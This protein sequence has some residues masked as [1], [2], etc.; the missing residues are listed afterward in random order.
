MLRG[1][2]SVAATAVLLWPALS[3]GQSSPPAPTI[4]VF[5]SYSINA[6]YIAQPFLIVVDQPVSPFLSTGG[7]PYGFEVSVERGFRRHLGLKASVSRYVDP[8]FGSAAYCQPP[9]LSL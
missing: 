8:F 7:G 9:L 6:D 2:R 5:G 4:R 1:F 3:S